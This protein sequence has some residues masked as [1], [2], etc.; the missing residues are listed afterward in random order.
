MKNN[1][2]KNYS[3]NEKGIAIVFTI[4][5]LALISSIALLYVLTTSLNNKAAKNNNDLVS[6]RMLARSAINR[7]MIAMKLY[8]GD[9]NNLKSRSVDY[10]LTSIEATEDLDTL[11]PTTVKGIEYYTTANYTAATPK[12]T[13]HYIKV[14][15]ASGTDV[16]IGRIVFSVAQVASESGWIMVGAAVDSGQATVY[17]KNHG[18]QQSDNAVTEYGSPA[19]QPTSAVSAPPQ[20]AR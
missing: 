5:L 2:A 20:T 15:N 1:I 16:I 4:G 13:W 18:G 3:K 10:T 12:P 17:Y 7:A 8:T 9:L 6:A 11:L 19:S 14:K